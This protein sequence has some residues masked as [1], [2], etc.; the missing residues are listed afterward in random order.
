MKLLKETHINFMKWKF[1]A[2]GLTLVIIVAGAVNI[3]TGRGL[4][5]GV[6]FGGG[7]LIRVVFKDVQDVSAIRNSLTSVGLGN[8][9]IQSTGKG[10]H[11]F[12]IRTRQVFQ[13]K[14]AEEELEAHAKLADQVIAAL[15]KREGA[16]AL[17]EGK[18]DLNT[19]DRTNLANLLD[20]SFPGE[21]LS[22][23][24]AVIGVRDE[25]NV[26]GTESSKISGILTSYDQLRDAGIKPEVV[27][28]LEEQTSLGPMAVVSRETVGPQA[29]AELRRK[30]TLAVVWSLIGMLIY[31]AIRFKLAY[32]VAAILTLTQDVLISLA[33]YS[34]TTREINLPVIA[35]LLTIVGYSINDTIVTFDRIRENLKTMRKDPLEKVM[36]TSINQMLGRTI[37]TAGTVFLT[38]MALYLFGGEVINDFAFVMLI[39][40]IEGVY[41]TLYLSCPVVLGW[42]KLFPP[43]RGFRK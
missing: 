29:G 25:Q 42:Q 34:F 22:L 39:G 5:M 14:S 26:L 1:V 33:I 7:T 6:D 35:A 9:L 8:S 3:F 16:A 38:V 31:I 20:L 30:A 21:G 27:K 24:A 32:G 28:A 36:N 12:M 4:R 37:I 15:E 18:P 2:L 43:K 13:G 23:A 40:T 19:I 17:P 10:G 41:S 11:E